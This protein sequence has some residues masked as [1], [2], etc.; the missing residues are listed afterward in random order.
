MVKS[1]G[2]RRFSFEEIEAVQRSYVA[3]DADFSHP[4]EVSYVLGNVNPVLNLDELMLGMFNSDFQF[5]LC[6][7]HIM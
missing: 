1:Y 5:P 6:D 7:L 2:C 3:D 4:V